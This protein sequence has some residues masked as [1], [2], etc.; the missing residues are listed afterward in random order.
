MRVDLELALKQ[1]DWWKNYTKVEE[2]K[3]DLCTQIVHILSQSRVSKSTKEGRDGTSLEA[4]RAVEWIFLAVSLTRTY[5]TWQSNTIHGEAIYN[6]TTN[7]IVEDAEKNV[8]GKM[9]EIFGYFS[10]FRKNQLK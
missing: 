2:D 4:S 10:S 5:K 1:W 3:W 6:T 7:V 9:W 8:L